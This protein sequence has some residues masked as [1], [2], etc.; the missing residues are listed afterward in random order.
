MA[1][2]TPARRAPMQAV[3][4]SWLA[5]GSHARYRSCDLTRPRG[6]RS[7]STHENIPAFGRRGF[8]FSYHFVGAGRFDGCHHRG[9]LLMLCPLESRAF[10]SAQESWVT[11]S[12]TGSGNG[13]NHGADKTAA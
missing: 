4:R 8:F 6:D 10:E 13:G 7:L 2:I 9:R 11:A 3:M 12:D 5:P 1:G